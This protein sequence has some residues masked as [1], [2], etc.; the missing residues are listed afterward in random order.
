MD[1][2]RRSDRLLKN[3]SLAKASRAIQVASRYAVR[4]AVF[5]AFDLAAVPFGCDG[6]IDMEVR[7]KRWMNAVWDG[8][9]GGEDGSESLTPIK[10][11]FRRRFCFKFGVKSGIDADADGDCFFCSRKRVLSGKG[12][13][14]QICQQCQNQDAAHLFRRCVLKLPFCVRS[15]WPASSRARS[16]AHHFSRWSERHWQRP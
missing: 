11:G 4:N 7:W 5:P 16:E 1:C 10:L 14:A 9:L 13:Q 12:E 8:L 6:H 3:S 2:A 15:C